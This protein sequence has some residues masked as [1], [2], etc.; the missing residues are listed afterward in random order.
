MNKAEHL[1]VVYFLFW[2]M[3]Q[4][5]SRLVKVSHGMRRVVIEARDLWMAEREQLTEQA[6]QDKEQAVLAARMETQVA[7][8]R[9]NQRDP[10]LSQ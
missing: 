1:S 5:S 6:K 8:S 2:Y 3:L 4:M 7:C 10:P 9:Y